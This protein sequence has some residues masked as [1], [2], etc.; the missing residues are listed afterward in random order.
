MFKPDSLLISH[1]FWYKYCLILLIS[2]STLN[3]LR[4]KDFAYLYYSLAFYVI[5]CLKSYSNGCHICNH[6]LESK[7]GNFMQC[8]I[9]SYDVYKMY[10]TG[11]RSFNNKHL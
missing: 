9:L 7:K 3:M 10:V 5:S 11:K 4:I 6:N 2:I 1:E 8:P